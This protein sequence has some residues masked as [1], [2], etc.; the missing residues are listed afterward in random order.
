MAF[1]AKEIAQADQDLN[2]IFAWLLEQEAG[3]GGL[4]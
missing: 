3:D 2:G 4:R 1:R